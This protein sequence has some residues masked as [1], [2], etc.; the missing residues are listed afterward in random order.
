MEETTGA[1]SSFA[2][3][4]PR[5]LRASSRDGGDGVNQPPSTLTMLLSRHTRRREFI[6][7]LGSAVAAWPSAARTQALPVIGFMSARSPEDTAPELKAFHTGLGEGG[8]T[9]GS[10]ATIEYRWARGDYR[11]MPSLADELLGRHVSVLVATGNRK[12]T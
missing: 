5:R 6:T 9:D 11:R 4:R 1:P 2:V 8:F 7:L 12:S 10:N 3:Y